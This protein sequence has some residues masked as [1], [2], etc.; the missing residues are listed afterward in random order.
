MTGDPLQAVFEINRKANLFPPNSRY[1]AIDTATLET[2]DG[3]PVTY[4][5][6]RFVPP[7][8][9]FALLQEHSVTDGDRLDNLAAQY[10]G[11]AEQFWRLCD[12]NAAMRPNELTEDPGRILRITLPEGL[13]GVPRA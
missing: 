3:R 12:A 10:L 11:D 5:R 9:L 7:P 1:H 4:L 2:V 6:R 8:S 13:P